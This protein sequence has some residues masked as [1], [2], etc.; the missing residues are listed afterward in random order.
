MK[1]ILIKV[2]TEQESENYFVDESKLKDIDLIKAIH[3]CRNNI[4]D[5][6]G[7]YQ[8]SQNII[9]QQGYQCN[10]TLNKLREDNPFEEI[11]IITC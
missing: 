1:K 9:F 7:V 2:S 6:F 10:E 4:E 8:V 5:T 11:S 3:A